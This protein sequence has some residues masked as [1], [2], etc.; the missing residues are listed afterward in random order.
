[1]KLQVVVHEA[2]V[3][4]SGRTSRQ[5]RDARRRGRPSR[6]SFRTPMKFREGCLSV[7]VEQPTVSG[8]DRAVEIVV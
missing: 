3:E 4:D 8:R 2:E 1:M 7:S 5:Y 6:N